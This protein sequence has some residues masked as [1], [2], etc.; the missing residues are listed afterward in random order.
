MPC[1]VN[2]WI[3]NCPARHIFQIGEKSSTDIGKAKL[4]KGKKDPDDLVLHCHVNGC[5]EDGKHFNA[6]GSSTKFVYRAEPVNAA[7]NEESLS[8]W[9]NRSRNQ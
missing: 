7:K 6:I 3:L 1:E 8:V 4:K 2:C 5:T 9:I